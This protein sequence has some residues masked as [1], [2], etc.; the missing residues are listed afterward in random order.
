[1][2][3]TSVEISWYLLIHYF[4]TVNAFS[5]LFNWLCDELVSLVNLGFLIK[6]S[7]WVDG[8]L[9]ECMLFDFFIWLQ[10]ELAWII[11]TLLNSYCHYRVHSKDVLF[12]QWVALKLILVERLM[13]G[14]R[15][16]LQSSSFIWPMLKWSAMHLVSLQVSC[17]LCTGT[18]QG[19]QSFHQVAWF[20]QS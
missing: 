15:L 11:W 16:L 19:F 9:S 20:Q 14:I 8:N 17:R 3:F 5:H 12:L 13:S 4:N 1:M 6:C 2:V 10:L 7:L 18:S